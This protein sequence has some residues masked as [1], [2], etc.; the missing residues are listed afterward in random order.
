MSAKGSECLTHGVKPD[1]SKSALFFYLYLCL[2]STAV[3]T[4]QYLTRR[5]WFYYCISI[6]SVLPLQQPIVPPSHCYHFQNF[7]ITKCLFKRSLS[8]QFL[9]WCALCLHLSF[10]LCFSP[11]HR[12]P[13]LIT[14]LQYQRPSG[15]NTVRVL[16]Q[17]VQWCVSLQSAVLN[18]SYLS[19][20]KTTTCF[21]WW[22]NANRQQDSTWNSGMLVI[23]ILEAGLSSISVTRT[24]TRS[25]Q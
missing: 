14:T 13:H 16:S 7:H 3:L 1:Y 24:T 11:C 15:S 4:C 21:S 8:T 6:V 17:C 22:P 5:L 19:F 18:S 25:L 20:K 9:K 2:C 23:L 10:M 12:V